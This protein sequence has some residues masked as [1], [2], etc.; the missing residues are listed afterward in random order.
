MFCIVVFSNLP[1][2]MEAETWLCEPLQQEAEELDQ[3][4][5]SQFSSE[6]I[7]G[8]AYGEL[9]FLQAKFHE[10]SCCQIVAANAS[11]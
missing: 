9:S 11:K 2:H 8:S 1:E 7:L 4:Y 6:A 3:F 5:S 10:C